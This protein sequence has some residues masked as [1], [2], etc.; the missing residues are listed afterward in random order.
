MK[1]VKAFSNTKDNTFCLQACIQSV[2][3]FYFPT[4]TF[5]ESEV[6]KNTGYHPKYFSWSPQAVV[7]LNSL[8]LN[9]KLYSPFNYNRLVNG[10]LAYLK[11]FKKD[12]Y[13]LE[14]KRGEYKFLPEIQKAAKEMVDRKLWIDQ[15]MKIED[16]ENQLSKQNTLCIGKTIYEW[17]DGH[18]IAG[19]SHFIVVVKKYSS[20]I[21]LIQD[22]GLPMV[23]NRKVNQ[24]INNHS[25]LG[26]IILVKN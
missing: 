3:N 25:I 9:V 23:G 18:Y 5:S 2:L 24:S 22:P 15:L 1:I 26:D 17:L 13:D 19:T 16:L 11:E 8:G 12:I 6:S 7:W 21:W 10:G 4:K 20:G 14:E